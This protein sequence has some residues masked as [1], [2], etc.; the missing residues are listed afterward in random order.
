LTNPGHAVW[1]YGLQPTSAQ[2]LVQATVADGQIPAVTALV[3]AGEPVR[4]YLD[5]LGAG[6]SRLDLHNR[7]LDQRTGD[8]L[9]ATVRILPSF[10]RAGGFDKADAG[11]EVEYPRTGLGTLL[12]RAKGEPR[13]VD[14]ELLDARSAAAAKLVLPTATA[15]FPLFDDATH[16]DLLPNNA[17]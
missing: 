3:A 1:S 5:V 2:S 15:V 16:G 4:W 10:L 7:S 14:G 17:Y 6:L 13:R 8:T 12:A 9:Y 11:V